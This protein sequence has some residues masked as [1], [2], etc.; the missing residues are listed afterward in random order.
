[1]TDAGGA[2]PLSEMDRAI[3]REARAEIAST[4]PPA[5]R[6]PYGCAVALAGVI[7]LAVTSVIPADL[8]AV[9][10]VRPF[11]VLGGVFMAVGGA[12]ASFFGGSSATA[13]AGAAVEASLRRLEDPDSDRETLL[14]AATLLVSHATTSTGPATVRVF[15]EPELRERVA[16]VRLLVDSVERHL[17]D[18]YG[19]E[20]TFTEAS[21]DF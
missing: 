5:N 17:V 21:T 20:S 3:V 16:P 6:G 13:A 8:A 2:V 14:R 18:E 7:L 12:V 9:S 1:M 11:L 15:S 10:F 19:Q 4:P